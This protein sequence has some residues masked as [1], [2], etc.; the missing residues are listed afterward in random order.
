MSV[1]KLEREEMSITFAT[2][3]YPL[4]SLCNH[5]CIPNAAPVKKFKD[6]ETALVTL[7]T[8]QPGEEICITYKP[9]FSNMKTK[10]RRTYLQECYNFLC[11]CTACCNNWCPK[12]FIATDD[13]LLDSATLFE[14]DNFPNCSECQM[15]QK[16]SRK[17][18]ESCVKLHLQ[19][20]AKVDDFENKLYHASDL[21]K[22]GDFMNAIEI[23]R[24]CLTYFSNHFS[25]CYTLTQVGLELF[26]R[27]LVKLANQAENFS[28][29]L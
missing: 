12:S 24:P 9:L 19:N 21:I 29:F 16:Q 28:P 20:V 14:L 11:N 27:A 22:K 25:S 7:K 18:C 13:L 23:L 1:S 3:V 6:L 26:K 15:N 10:E 5:S 8:L 4:I 2:A 17:D